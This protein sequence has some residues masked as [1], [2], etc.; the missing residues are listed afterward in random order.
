M[1]AIKKAKCKNLFNKNGDEMLV[2]PTV[3]DTNVIKQF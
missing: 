2:K 3:R 1:I